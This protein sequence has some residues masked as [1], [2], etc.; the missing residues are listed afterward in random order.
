VRPNRT[1]KLLNEGKVTFGSWATMIDPEVVEIAGLA[2]FDFCFID[3]EHVSTDTLLVEHMIRAADATG[4]TPIVRMADNNPK[5]ILR[6]LEAGAQGIVVPHIMSGDDASRLVQAVRYPPVG[7]RGISPT[8]RSAQYSL[9]DFDNHM[10]ESNREIMAIAF[11]E[12]KE[13]VEDFEAIVTTPGLDAVFIGPYDLAGSYGVPDGTN[14]P[15]T[16]NAIDHMFE[17]ARRVGGAQI[18]IPVNHRMYNKSAP[19]LIDLGATMIV[20]AFDYS[21]IAQGMKQTIESLAPYRQR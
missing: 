3:M 4:I 1:K 11:I 7:T 19:E 15:E 5:A 6:V 13:A 16:V 20:T 2:G 18:G 8:S 17:V 21:I 10:R 12:D 14:P 9:V